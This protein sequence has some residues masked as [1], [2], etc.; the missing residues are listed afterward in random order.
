MADAVLLMGDKQ[1]RNMTAS[2]VQGSQPELTQVP[3]FSVELSD[4]EMHAVEQVLRSGWLTTGQQTA[5]FEREF[6]DFIGG[7]VQA[8]AVNS[9]TAGMH[10]AL[11]A[12]GVKK[13]DEVILPTLTFTATAEVVRYLNADPVFVDVDPNT[14]CMDSEVVARKV[15]SRTRAIMPVHFGGLAC[16]MTAL[17]DLARDA[18]LAIVEDAAHAFP[19]EHAG[20]LVGS[21]GSDAAVFSF[22]ANKTITTGEGGMIVSRNEELMRRVRVMRLHGIDRD[23]FGRHT[24]APSQWR[25]DVV[26]PGFKY[27]LTDI[28]AA[29]GRGQLARAY[30]LKASRKRIAGL[31]D[32]AFAGLPV[33]RPPRSAEED[34]HSH[35]LYVLEVPD[36]AP[37]TRDQLMTFLDSRGIGYSVH[38]IPLHQLSYWRDR[39]SLRDEDFPVATT[40]ARQCISLPL[41]PSMKDRDIDSVIAAVIDAFS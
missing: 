2:S 34:G 27:N 5:L 37:I 1:R 36:N 9:N 18:G 16:D 20:I 21:H 6:A 30:A 25:Y 28:G 17:G 11:E 24:D 10:L 32:K 23:V 12:L 33:K 13:G 39:Y 29:I 14:K 40:Y 26:A 22:Y 15:T 8:A 41:F 7:G 19:T 31:Y 3:F 35:H 38:Y 4:A